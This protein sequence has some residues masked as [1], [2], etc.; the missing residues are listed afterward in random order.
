[1]MM[2]RYVCSQ[3]L[4]ECPKTPL[5]H[6]PRCCERLTSDLDP[7]VHAVA[8]PPVLCWLCGAGFLSQEAFYRH[9][10]ETHGDYAEYRKHLFWL[11]QKLGFLPLLP[12]QKRHML[13]NLSFFQCFSIPGTGAMEWSEDHSLNTAKQRQ[14]VGCAIC[15]RKDWIEY[16]YPVYLWRE[17]DEANT[18]ED[19]DPE[20]VLENPPVQD[21]N[22]ENYNACTGRTATVSTYTKN[23]GCY[24]LGDADKL[25]KLLA[26]SRYAKL[27]P[28]IPEEDLYASS[29]EHPR[30]PE[31]TWL[32]HTRRVKCLPE[33]KPSDSRCAGIGDIDATVWCCKTCIQNLCR[34]KAAEIAMPPPALANLLWLGREHISWQTASLGTRMLSCL[35]RPVWRKLILGKGDKDEQEKGI[36]G[37]CILLAQARPQEL[38]T[39]LPPTTA[40]MQDTLV[41]LFARS[42]EEVS[43]AQALVVNRQDWTTL[44]LCER[45][46]ECAR[47]TQIFHLMKSKCSNCLKTACHNNSLHARSTSQRP[48]KSTFPR[49]VLLLDQLT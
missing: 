28:T 47:S 5:T 12:W 14:E 22:E 49:L 39:S 32:L 23:E 6:F 29:I 31:M 24:C 1:M 10:R 37:N 45:G 30:H 33:K 41:V 7:E 4:G 35:G 2:K 48:N 21:A 40:Q 42:I 38:A 36:G 8:T 46:A 3:Q 27:M 15:A 26:T 43:R 11:A 25:N 18:G 9:T 44:L 16:R 13:A 34:P 19:I 20:V 17:P